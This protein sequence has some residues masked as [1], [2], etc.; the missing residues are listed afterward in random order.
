VVGSLKIGNFKPSIPKD[1]S[2]PY[3]SNG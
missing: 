3:L 1:P 2:G